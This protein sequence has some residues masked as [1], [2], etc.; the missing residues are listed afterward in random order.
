VPR[1]NDTVEGILLEYAD[2][3]SILS[4]DPFKPRAY[5]KA[6]RAVGGFP[7]DV[8]TLDLNGILSIP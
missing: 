7:A 5:E 2:L 6:A 3:L 1:A 8:S 4:E